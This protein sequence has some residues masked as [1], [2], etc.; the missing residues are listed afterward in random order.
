[1][2]GF[3]NR[4]AGRATQRSDAQLLKKVE[5]YIRLRAGKSE[6]LE[7]E[8][9]RFTRSLGSREYARFDALIGDA[10]QYA[11]ARRYQPGTEQDENVLWGTGP[12]AAQDKFLLR[13]I[14]IARERL[15]MRE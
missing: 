9:N 1:M 11:A 3:L 15:A 6:D 10:L 5:A 7:P 8:V 12:F 13:L 14:E 2:S 4:L